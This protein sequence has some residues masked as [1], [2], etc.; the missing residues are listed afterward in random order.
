[1]WYEIRFAAMFGL[2]VHRCGT[3]ALGCE[4]RAE[5]TRVKYNVCDGRVVLCNAVVGDGRRDVE[6]LRLLNGYNHG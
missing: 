3:R 6:A 1:M 4:Y 2:E 5:G